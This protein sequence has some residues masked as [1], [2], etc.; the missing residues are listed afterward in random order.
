MIFDIGCNKGQ[1]A[2]FYLRKGFRVVAV[3]ANP[4]LCED[5]RKRFADAISLGRLVLVDKA[6]AEKPGPVTF[7][8]NTDDD[9]Q[10]TIVPSYAA[11]G[12]TIE[13]KVDAIAFSSLIEGAD[14]LCLKGLLGS[15]DKPKFISIER[16]ISFP[17]QREQFSLLRALGYNRFQIVDQTTVPSQ[18]PPNPPREGHYVM[19][20]FPIGSTGLFGEELPPRKWVGYSSAMLRNLYILVRAGVFPRVP[21]LGRLAMHQKWFDI[22]AARAGGHQQ[23]RASLREDAAGHLDHSQKRNG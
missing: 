1:D 13:T 21:G 7:F 15:R 9:A 14:I 6:I 17:A 8:I 16:V 22:H 4:L 5:L 11:R 23:V 10:G 19:Q 20:T 18:I 12:N 2:D 3:E